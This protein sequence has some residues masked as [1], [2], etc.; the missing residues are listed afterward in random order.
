VFIQTRGIRIIHVCNWYFAFFACTYCT[1]FGLVDTDAETS[2]DH[3][4]EVYNYYHPKFKDLLA[5]ATDVKDWQLRQ[6]PSLP[7]WRR[8]RV[9]IMGDAAHAMFPSTSR[10]SSPLYARDLKS[11]NVAYG[12]GYAMGLEDAAVLAA[13]LPLGIPTDSEDIPKRLELYEKIRKPRAEKVSKMSADRA[14]VYKRNFEHGELLRDRFGSQ[15]D[16]RTGFSDLDDEVYGYD[17]VKVVS[18]A[19]KEQLSA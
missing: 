15:T 5:L 8:G 1:F 16:I 11:L 14:D 17:V 4:L 6:L 10:L 7:T 13:L 19:L 2:V 9:I 3:L 18:T 12:Q